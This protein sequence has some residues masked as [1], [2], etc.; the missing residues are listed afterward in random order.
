MEN[1]GRRRA[2]G[3]AL[4]LHRPIRQAPRQNLG[5]IL[6]D[7]LLKEKQT[8]ETQFGRFVET[9]RKLGC[10]EDKERFEAALGKIAAHRPPKKSPAPQKPKECK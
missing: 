6:V 8:A 2:P 10:D 7:K 3:L 1:S 5:D 9:A 4:R